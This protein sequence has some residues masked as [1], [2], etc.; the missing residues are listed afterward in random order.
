M[1]CEFNSVI[2]AALAIESVSANLRESGPLGIILQVAES[3][4]QFLKAAI[5]HQCFLM[6]EA[7][8]AG[9]IVG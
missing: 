8:I 7:H 5:A 1:F 6:T 4:I 2:L 9:S 3:E